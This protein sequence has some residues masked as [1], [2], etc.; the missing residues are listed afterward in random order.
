MPAVPDFLRPEPGE[1][2]PP[3][4]AYVREVPDVD[5]LLSM[6]RQ[7]HETTALL[8]ALPGEKA[9]FAYAPGK[10]TVKQ[11]I[12]HLID[13]ERIFSYR[14]LRLARGDSTP[15][16]GFDENAYVPASAAERRSIV[17]LL[18]ELHAVRRASL[19]LFQHLPAEAPTRTGSVNGVTVSV[20][21]LVW[22]I[23][24]HERHH[25]RILKERY[26]S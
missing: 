25:L 9:D 10:W 18:G 3:H 21:A 11:V 13:A 23:A 26:L 6:E 14:A 24:G 8:E 19:A 15:L 20:R 12:G 7:I 22:V 5:V 4:F 17:D 1:C 2:A 16:P